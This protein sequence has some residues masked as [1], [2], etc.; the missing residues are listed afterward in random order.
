MK[1]PSIQFFL[2]C[3]EVKYNNRRIVITPTKSGI[4]FA[5]KRAVTKE[6]K[7]K[8]AADPEWELKTAGTYVVANRTVQTELGLTYDIAMLLGQTLMQYQREIKTIQI[9]NS[10]IKDEARSEALDIFNGALEDEFLACVS[11]FDEDRGNILCLRLDDIKR[12]LCGIGYLTQNE[13]DHFGKP[14]T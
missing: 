1:Q 3:L 11:D 9:L 8:F 12:R 2:N 13:N 6:E 7:D 14:L 5:F 10:D 4:N